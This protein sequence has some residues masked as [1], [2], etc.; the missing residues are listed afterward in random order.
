LAFG[1]SRKL[2]SK[3]G[4]RKRSEARGVSKTAGSPLRTMQQLR[5]LVDILQFSSAGSD[6]EILPFIVP[7]LQ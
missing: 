4:R 3:G 7:H 2:H 1:T 5:F 6:E